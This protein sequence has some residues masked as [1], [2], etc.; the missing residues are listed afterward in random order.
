[1]NKLKVLYEEL[2]VEKKKNREVREFVIKMD[3]QTYFEDQLFSR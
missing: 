2:I 3:R 1:M